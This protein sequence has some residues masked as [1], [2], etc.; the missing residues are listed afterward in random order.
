MRERCTEHDMLLLLI[1]LA[2][3]L[4]AL[5]KGGHRL[6]GRSRLDLLEVRRL[7]LA[8]GTPGWGEE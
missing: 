4:R 2:P 5:V 3:T 1:P 6:V 8:V 7:V